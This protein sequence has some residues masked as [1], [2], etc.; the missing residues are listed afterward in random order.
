MSEIK[1]LFAKLTEFLSSLEAE[2]IFPLNR[3][4]SDTVNVLK[5]FGIYLAVLIVCAALWV[6]L[7]G[8]FILGVIVKIICILATLYS[9]VGM[10]VLA[11]DFM[12]YN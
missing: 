10:F 5:I 9:V 2:D 6:F 8:I 11:L 1:N 4:A 12:R 7:G 3:R